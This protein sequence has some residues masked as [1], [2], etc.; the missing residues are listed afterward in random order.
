[1]CQGMPGQ[2]FRACD[3]GRGRVGHSTHYPGRELACQIALRRHGLRVERQCTLIQ[4]DRLRK[5]LAGLRFVQRRGSRPENVV[6]RVGMLGR[7]R[8]L[9]ADQL[10]VERDCDPARDL[11][12]QSEEIA[13][14]AIP[15]AR[16]R[17]AH[18]SRRRS[19]GR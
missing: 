19:A 12:L 13:Q 14:V 2:V 9:H 18:R 15:T 16:P 6:Q 7:P 1:M 11:V 8:G 10:K 17:D 4:A 3:V 5:I